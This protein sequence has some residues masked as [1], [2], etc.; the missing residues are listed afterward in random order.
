[1]DRQERQRFET[2]RDAALEL[3]GRLQTSILAVRNVGA[4]SDAMGVQTLQSQYRLNLSMLC[5]QYLGLKQLQ[6]SYPNDAEL[7]NAVITCEAYFGD[8]NVQPPL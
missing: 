2:L 3:H 5:E 8:L 6:S 7:A 4:L 1:M